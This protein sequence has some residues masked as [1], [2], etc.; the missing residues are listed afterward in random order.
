MD[1]VDAAVSP[2]ATPVEE[3]FAAVEGKVAAVEETVADVE[4]KVAEVDETLPPDTKRRLLSECSDFT[5]DRLV[6]L[7]NAVAT[8]SSYDISAATTD[9]VNRNP[10]AR[11]TLMTESK[12]EGYKVVALV[13]A[14]V[15]DGSITAKASKNPDFASFLDQSTISINAYQVYY[16]GETTERTETDEVEDG[17]SGSDLE[18]QEV[19]W[20]ILF[21]TLCTLIGVAFYAG[22]LWKKKEDGELINERTHMN[23]QPHLSYDPKL[24]DM[25]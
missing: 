12:E 7:Q 25:L 18:N 16:T 5:S 6:V 10:L 1:E 2:V 19:F 17:N 20:I 21:F 4:G 22:Y 23:S 15:E 8:L 11:L 9:C 24:T 13:K 3:T 14:L